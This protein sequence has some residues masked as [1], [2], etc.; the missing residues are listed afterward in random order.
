MA[1]GTCIV[2]T[3]IYKQDGTPDAGAR[4][5]ARL[6]HWDVIDSE[7][8]VGPF[9]TEA[10]ANDQGYVELALVPN[11]RGSAETVY[12]I[13]LEGSERTF[14][15][16]CTVPDLERI[17]LED[18]AVLPP[19]EGKNDGDLLVY[20]AEEIIRD[21]IQEA[22]NLAVEEATEEAEEWRDQAKGFRDEAEV[23]RDEAEATLTTTTPLPPTEGVAVNAEWV[24]PNTGRRYTLIDDGDSVQWVETGAAIALTDANNQI[25][26]DAAYAAEQARIGAESVQHYVEDT[27]QAFQ[28]GYT[29]FEDGL[30]YDFGQITSPMT[31]FNRDFGGLT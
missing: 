3:H 25:A 6:T 23:F 5:M 9:E 30:G 20:H 1:L 8:Y 13:R 11:E 15:T 22:T 18:I 4:L 12:R 17:A 10:V 2:F 24:D 28:S 21:A 7:G 31:Y 16:T 27:I 14:N 26:V 29:G 19:Y